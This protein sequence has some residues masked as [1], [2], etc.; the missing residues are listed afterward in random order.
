[1]CL[2]NLSPNISCS[3]GYQNVSSTY[4]TSTGGKTGHLDIPSGLSLDPTVC[5]ACSLD[6]TMGLAGPGNGGG[7]YIVD[8]NWGAVSGYSLSGCPVSSFIV[9]GSGGGAY[10]TFSQSFVVTYY[11]EIFSRNKANSGFGGGLYATATGS[12]TFNLFNSQFFSNQ[13]SFG[14]GGGAY[15]NGF[16]TVNI[17]GNVLFLRFVP[18]IIFFSQD[19]PFPIT[20]HSWVGDCILRIMLLW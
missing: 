19:H 18:P 5:F 1:M 15:L 14:K 2:C 12:M 11:D 8:S 3:G 6:S 13:A 16:N 10:Y 17:T 20:M 9:P 7:Y 4:R